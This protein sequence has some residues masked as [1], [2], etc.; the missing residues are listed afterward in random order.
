MVNVLVVDDNITDLNGIVE[1]VPWD[2]IN[3]RVIGTARNGIEGI[4]KAKELSPDIIITDISMP[5]MDGI[6]MCRNIKEFLP[7]AF[8]IFISC[9]EDFETARSAIDLNATGYVTKPINIDDII[10]NILKATNIQQEEINTSL[11]IYNL[12]KQIQRNIPYLTENFFRNLLMRTDSQSVSQVASELNIPLESPM[13]LVVCSIEG[14]DE[15]G[16]LPLQQITNLIKNKTP[17]DKYGCSINYSTQIIATILYNTGLD[18]L[19]DCFNEIHSELSDI[20]TINLTTY[21]GNI[22]NDSTSLADNF[23]LILNCINN[24]YVE[25]DNNI[26]LAHEIE[27]T[28]HSCFLDIDKIAQEIKLELTDEER[29]LEEFVD[30]YFY[31]KNPE[32]ARQIA[33][34]MYFQAELVLKEF[35]PTAISDNFIESHSS[36]INSIILAEKTQEV[37]SIILPAL[38]T[39]KDKLAT[40]NSVASEYIVKNIIH[41]IESQYQTIKSAEDISKQI[42]LSL[43]YLNRVFKAKT[44]F[45]IYDYLL[46]YRMEV[47][48]KLLSNLRYKAYEVAE[49]VGYSNNAYFSTAF[50][51]HTGLTPKQYKNKFADKEN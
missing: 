33:F 7:K 10:K 23:E 45:T 25:F 4:E 28:S 9:L 46:N 30:R 43:P 26:V 37:K 18:E 44:G 34:T 12:K 8:F 1:C 31:R 39:V 47:A 15:N 22:S 5:Q 49:L 32:V 14:S 24:G 29:D 17:A 2:S 20:F 51:K 42:Y 40:Q 35:V 6:E 13:A 16:F 50:K 19:I 38:K 3:C 36:L 41:I 21:I 27:E 11:T 48:K